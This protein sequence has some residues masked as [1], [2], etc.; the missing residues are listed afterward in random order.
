MITADALHCQPDHVDYLA[1]RGAHWV[2]IVKDNQPDLHVQLRALPWRAVPDGDRVEDRGHGRREIRIV[3]VLTLT[4]GIDFP[5][6]SQAIRIQR[7]RRRLGQP[8]RWTLRLSTG[9]PICPC[10]TPNPPNWPR[11]P[12]SLVDREQGS[13]GPRRH[14]RRRPVPNPYRHR[15]PGS[16]QLYPTPPSACS[17]WPASP[18]SQPPTATTPRQ[19]PFGLA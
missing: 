7:R 3:K 11:G 5:Q 12:R 14:L 8:K 4:Q 2:L 13:L 9:S 16:W 19:H 18:I 10:T 1:Q 17:A 6:A 15:R